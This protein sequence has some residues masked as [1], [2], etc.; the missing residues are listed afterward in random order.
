M[1]ERPVAGFSGFL[2]RHTLPA[3][4]MGLGAL[5]AVVGLASDTWGILQL[6]LPLRVW[7]AAGAALFFICVIAVLYKWD[8]E[9]AGGRSGNSPPDRR[10]ARS[11]YDEEAD[12]ADA[13]TRS[14]AGK[15][16]WVTDYT[17]KDSAMGSGALYTAYVSE[18]SNSTHLIWTEREV[19]EMRQQFMQCLASV[20]R[21]RLNGDVAQ[22]RTARADLEGVA[23]KLIRRLKS[24]AS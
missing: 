21:A 19:N 11:I 18:L 7:S 24:K 23:D 22:L 14:L 10:Q 6:G 15:L 12:L 2:R 9:H 1:L 4:G 13:A 5:I 20:D 17:M 3:V 16:R 8:Q